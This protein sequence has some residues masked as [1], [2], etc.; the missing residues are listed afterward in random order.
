ML[1]I[2]TNKP[3]PLADKI[4]GVLFKEH[5]FA[6]VIGDVE[7][8]P[9]KPDPQRMLAAME[10]LGIKPE[11]SVFIGDGKPDIVTAKRAGIFACGVSWGFKGLEELEGADLLINHPSELLHID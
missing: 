11:D 10:K 7:G 2:F 5:T 3:Q 9:M 4:A 1:G 6:F 8:Q